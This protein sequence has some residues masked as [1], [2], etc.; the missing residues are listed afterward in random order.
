MRDATK[1]G[2]AEPSHLALLEDRVAIEHGRKQIYG[3]QIGTD[4]QTQNHYALPLDA[5]EN[6]DLRR[7]Q[8]GL[9]PMAIYLE[10]WQI[11]WDAEQYK[12]DLPAIETKQKTSKN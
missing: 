5:P 10:K 1:K 3:S 6:V 8:V 4:R 7:A 9:P 2:N 12:K 11:K